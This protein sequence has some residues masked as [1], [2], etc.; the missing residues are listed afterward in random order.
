METTIKKLSIKPEVLS[1]FLP[2]INT[3]GTYYE[4]LRLEVPVRVGDVVGRIVI[5]NSTDYD[6]PA[7]AIKVQTR[8][9]GFDQIKQFVDIEIEDLVVTYTDSMPKWKDEI[10]DQ[11][12]VQCAKVWDSSWVHGFIKI[13]K[14]LNV[15]GLTCSIP[16][17]ESFIESTYRPSQ[18]NIALSYRNRATN[19]SREVEKGNVKYVLNR[20][21]EYGVERDCR[22]SKPETL[23]ASFIKRVDAYWE[24]K[25][26]AKTKEEKRQE[27]IKANIQK[28]IGLFGACEHEATTHRYNT[29][30]RKSAEYITDGYYIP[31]KD[32]TFDGK[33]SKRKVKISSEKDGFFMFSN[34]NRLTQSDVLKMIDILNGD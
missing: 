18:V 23:I 30:P 3:Q 7:R 14:L 17:R 12:K 22:Y 20:G 33:I 10:V 25:D 31:L 1:P 4:D 6:D 5:S 19:P 16:S 11:I 32:R 9:Y 24:S 15:P 28:Y 27:E 21:W 2:E 34:F 26:Y 8:L 13:V 29:A